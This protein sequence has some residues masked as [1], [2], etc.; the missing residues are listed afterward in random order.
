VVEIGATLQQARI[1]RGL[2]LVQI[3]NATKISRRVL[4]QIEAGLFEELPG[5]LLTRG[6]LR[7]FAAEVAL[8]PEAIVREYRAEFER[9]P[10]DEPFK[11]R[12]SYAD[13]EPRAPGGSVILALASA[14]IIYVAFV[15]PSDT[16]SEIETAAEPAAAGVAAIAA[17]EHAIVAP[18]TVDSGSAPPV[19]AA[20]PE[21]LQI[22]LRPRAD[23][24]VSARVDG[25]LVIYRLMRGGER[26]TIDAVHEIVLRV[27]DAGVLTYAVNGLTGRSLGGP[28]EAVTVRVTSD[29]AATWRTTE[30]AESAAG[31]MPTRAS[32]RPVMGI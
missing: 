4:Q 20:H 18:Q 12:K 9:T 23:C 7:A 25:H 17:I 29:N 32:D 6:Y 26:E 1:D 21:G 3:S 2:S 15:T 22:E 16:P 11:L 28:G 27:G 13:T 10:P 31:T 30:P 14:V 24:W 8:D 19:Q 5:G